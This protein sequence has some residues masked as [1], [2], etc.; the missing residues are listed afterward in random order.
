MA[1][2]IASKLSKT[3]MMS[4]LLGAAIATRFAAVEESSKFQ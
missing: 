2:R 3:V 1:R 4:L